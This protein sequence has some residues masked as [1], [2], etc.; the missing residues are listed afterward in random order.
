MIQSIRDILKD[1]LRKKSLSEQDFNNAYQ[2]LLSQF[3]QLERYQDT[4]LW[5]ESEL[6]AIDSK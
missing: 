6:K 2:K 3:N 5:L 4:F 1:A